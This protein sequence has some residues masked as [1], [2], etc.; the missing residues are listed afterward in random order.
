MG[1]L[2][3]AIA[4]L[5]FSWSSSTRSK[6][7]S[8]KIATWW[9]VGRGS[10][11][12]LGS[13][14]GYDELKSTVIHPRTWDPGMRAISILSICETLCR[15]V[16]FMCVLYPSGRG[17]SSNIVQIFSD[18]SIAR[19]AQVRDQPVVCHVMSREGLT[20]SVTGNGVV[21]HA[22]IIPYSG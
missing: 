4:R 6:M 1:V 18:L 15:Q 21:F 19:N 3:R 20:A 11:G 13:R 14:G 22:P 2:W 17:L 16:L 9:R 5:S 10:T 12:R 8:E 7:F